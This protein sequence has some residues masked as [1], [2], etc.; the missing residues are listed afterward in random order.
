M[1]VYVQRGVAIS[2][3]DEEKDVKKKR[4]EGKLS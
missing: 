1:I 3:R 4:G 2:S